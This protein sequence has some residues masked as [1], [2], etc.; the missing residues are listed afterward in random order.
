M[1][2]QAILTAVKSGIKELSN[3]ND[4]EI[5]LWVEAA[6]RFLINGGV[7]EEKIYNGEALGV[8]TLIVKKLRVGDT[9]FGEVCRMMMYQLCY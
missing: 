4:D 8:I 6:I 2:K 3:Y 5:M 9:E 1:D 7:S